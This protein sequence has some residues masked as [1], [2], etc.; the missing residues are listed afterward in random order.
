MQKSF[1]RSFL[2][3]LF[4]FVLSG[5]AGPQR[6]TLDKLEQDTFRYFWETTDKTT[7][8]APDRYPSKA[9]ASIAAVGFALTSYPIGVENGYITRKQAVERTLNTLRFFW[10]L[11]LGPE[12]KGV[13][14]Y[15]GFY[16]HFLKMKDGTRSLDWEIELSTI[17][18]A[19]LMAGVLFSQSYFDA[20]DKNEIEIRELADKLYR[21][22][23]WQWAQNHTPV[24]TLGWFPNKGFLPWDWVG[25]NEGMLIYIL[26][27]GSPTYPI[28]EDAWNA[29]TAHYQDD[30]GVDNGV[31][32]LTFAPMFGHQ[33]SHI[34]IDFRDIQDEFMK[35]K[36]S[37]YFENSRKATY[38]QRD[39]AIANPGSWVGYGENLWGL[40][41]SDGPGKYRQK[42]N[43][44]KRT[45]RGYSARGVGPHS[46]FDDGTLAPTALV[47]SL[48]FAPE[49]V[50]PAMEATYQG[51]G[52][53]LYTKYGFLDAFN[54]SFRFNL[55]SKTGTVIPGVGWISKDYIGIDQ[56]AILTMIENYQSELIWR[57][58]RK[59]P[60]VKRGLERAGFTGWWL[61]KK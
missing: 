34:W 30:W 61:Q 48:P 28:D 26:A 46:A 32:Y 59:N 42:V 16:Y 12:R 31:E 1:F 49:I 56:G 8:L 50:I 24:I 5:F 22:V 7:G 38:A 25:Y 19:M 53:H 33:Y 45:F 51:Y 52:K 6:L 47:G 14:G 21:R 55:N 11:P 57:T 60:Y 29:W 58:M 9:P 41:A 37:N 43:G 54:P 40:T 17:D 13:S 44:T 36:N 20:D 35:S 27:L 18:T 39:Y 10:S 2:L 15:Q 3:V 4:F 23:N